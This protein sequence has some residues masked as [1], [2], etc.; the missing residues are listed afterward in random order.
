MVIIAILFLFC[1]KTVPSAKSVLFR[2][3]FTISYV[4]LTINM[5]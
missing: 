5:A 4:P 3:Y 2:Y 1:K